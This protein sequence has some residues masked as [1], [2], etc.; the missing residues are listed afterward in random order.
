MRQFISPQQF[1]T[2][3]LQAQA[4]LFLISGL[5]MEKRG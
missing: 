1:V 3:A 4:S 5:I 2:I